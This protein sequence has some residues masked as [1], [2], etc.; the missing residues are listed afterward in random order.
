MM[1]DNM[2]ND[3]SMKG[4]YMDNMMNV[5]Q[6]DTYIFKMMLEKTMGMCDTNPARCKMMMGAMQSHPNVMNSMKGI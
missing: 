6:T 4:M 1:M 3:P 5:S 2:M